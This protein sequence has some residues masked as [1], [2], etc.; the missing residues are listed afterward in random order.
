[1]AIKWS[2]GDKM[3]YGLPWLDETAIDLD[4]TAIQGDN[5]LRAIKWSTGCFGLTKHSLHLVGRLDKA[6]ISLIAVDEI[7]SCVD[8]T[9]IGLGRMPLA[10]SPWFALA[11]PS[12]QNRG[13]QTQTPNPEPK[14]VK[15]QAAPR[16]RS[17]KKPKLQIL[18]LCWRTLARATK[19]LG[20][21]V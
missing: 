2:T 14:T 18:Y 4:K 9:A 11:R 16:R 13:P 10:S 20:F 3:V 7:A 8:N 17:T 12:S 21:R 15:R 1:M 6:A 5:G 19:S